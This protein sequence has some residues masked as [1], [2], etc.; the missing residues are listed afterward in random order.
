[1]LWARPSPLHEYALTTSHG[2]TRRRRPWWWHHCRDAAVVK[3][4]PGKIPIHNSFSVLRSSKIRPLSPKTPPLSVAK[5]CSLTKRARNVVDCEPGRP[6][7][8]ETRGRLPKEHS[9]ACAVLLWSVEHGGDHRRMSRT[10]GPMFQA[11][12]QSFGA[13]LSLFEG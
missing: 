5:G 7:S 4:G 11:P 3:Y 1:M 9:A 6:P 2:C 8:R 13:S 12:G 10:W